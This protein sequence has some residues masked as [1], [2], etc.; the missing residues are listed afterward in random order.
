MKI[1]NRCPHS[2]TLWDKYGVSIELKPTQPPVRLMTNAAAKVGEVMGVP[3]HG[4]AS[5]AGVQFLPDKRDDTL[6]VVSQMTAL[7]VSAL[8][9]DRDDVVYPGTAPH[10]HPVRDKE[11]RDIRG[12][13]RLIRAIDAPATG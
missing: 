1:E 6:I 10:D 2:V 3:I 7:A 8:H 4:P 11:R 5:F 12:V 9:P 13:T